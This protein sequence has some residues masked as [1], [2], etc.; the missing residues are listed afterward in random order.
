LEVFAREN[1]LPVD[2]ASTMEAMEAVRRAAER[3]VELFA[4]LPVSPFD[5]PTWPGITHLP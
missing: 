4:A 3:D 1:S 2:D 5:L